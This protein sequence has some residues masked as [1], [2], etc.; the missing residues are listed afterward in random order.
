MRNPDI[1]S[2]HAFCAAG[3][4]ALLTISAGTYERI[5]RYQE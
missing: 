4:V 1:S 2:G 3:I 5:G